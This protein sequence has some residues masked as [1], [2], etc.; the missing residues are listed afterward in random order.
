MGGRARGRAAGPARRSLDA[1]QGRRGAGPLD[2]R[3]VLPAG[4]GPARRR[5]LPPRRRLRARPPAERLP[6]LVA[7]HAE[8]RFEVRLRGLDSEL[9]GFP[10]EPSAVADALTYCDMTVGSAGE[11][12]TLHERTVDIAQRYGDDHA[13]TRSLAWSMPYLSLSLARTERRLRLRGV[14]P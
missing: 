9:E 4:P 11:L 14:T 10:R 6:R 3:R 1:F 12:M 8:A 2:G 7:H 13:A 5:R